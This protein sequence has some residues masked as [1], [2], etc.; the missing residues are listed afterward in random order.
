MKIDSTEVVIQTTETSPDG[1]GT[2]KVEITLD[3]WMSDIEEEIE[4]IKTHLVI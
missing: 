1:R 2:I 4:R 3:D